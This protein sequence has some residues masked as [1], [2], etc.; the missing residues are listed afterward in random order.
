MKRHPVTPSSTYASALFFTILLAIATGWAL[1]AKAAVK[2]GKF[3]VGSTM[4]LLVN[5]DTESDTKPDLFQLNLGYRLTDKDVLSLEIIA[6]KYYAPLGIPYGPSKEDKAERY[7]GVV[8]AEGV[9]LAYQRF[10]WGRAYTALHTQYM[11]HNY[12]D[13]SGAKIGS[14]H[15]VFMTF[16]LG[17]H[18]SFLNDVAFIEPNLAITHWP[19]NTGLPPSFQAKEDKWPNYF[20]FEPGLH[21]GFAF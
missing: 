12:L 3:F 19:V 20:L 17:Y 21:F 16:R 9:G 13:E 14:G 4:F 6:W 18:F 7:P 8:D 15:Q 11:D 2:P 1:P 10:I 5:L